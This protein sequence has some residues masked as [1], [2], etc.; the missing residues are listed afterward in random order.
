MFRGRAME[1]MEEEDRNWGWSWRWLSGWR[2]GVSETDAL[3]SGVGSRLQ[4][5]TEGKDADC[6][7]DTGSCD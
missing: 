6:P 5:Y 7:D 2:A 1:V 4:R 3:V